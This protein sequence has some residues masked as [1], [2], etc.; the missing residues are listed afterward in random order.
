MI[1][2]PRINLCCSPE[3][4]GRNQSLPLSASS[5]AMGARS[6]EIRA[7]RE[8]RFYFRG[9]LVHVTAYGERWHAIKAKQIRLVADKLPLDLQA[10][11]SADV[12]D[13]NISRSQA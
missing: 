9:C 5:Q 4:S 1:G 8:M 3:L 10:E 2:W 7:V 6:S 12:A 11:Y 13:Q